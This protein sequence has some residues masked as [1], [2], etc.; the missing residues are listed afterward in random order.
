MSIKKDNREIEE[1]DKD[2]R[3][4][5]QKPEIDRKLAF[6]KGT[7]LA[8]EEMFNSIEERIERGYLTEKSLL[9]GFIP[10]KTKKIL[11]SYDIGKL[12]VEKHELEAE[13]FAK[14]GFYQQWISRSKEYEVRFEELTLECNT[15]FLDTFEKAKEVAIKNIRL[16]QAMDRYEKEGNADQKTRNEF[17]LFIR[18]EVTNHFDYGK[19]A[20]LR[21]N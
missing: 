12:R 20:P 1:I 17:Y 13:V 2:V 7:M 3:L 21:V 18:K 11:D 8:I 16:A 9:L 14:K 10:I 5:S 6:Y 19:K 4:L 15:H